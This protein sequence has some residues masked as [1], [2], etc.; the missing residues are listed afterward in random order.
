[1]IPGSGGSE[2][3]S[4]YETG[5][6]TG[7]PAGALE[8]SDERVAAFCRFLAAVDSNNPR[9]GI[10]ATRELRRLGLSCVL[11]RPQGQGGGR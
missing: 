1:M 7:S 5:D 10:V 4:R 8:P 11:I 6:L 3:S 2:K 9:E